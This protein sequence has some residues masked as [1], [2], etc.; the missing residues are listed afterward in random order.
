MTRSRAM[1]ASASPGSKVSCITQQPPAAS[2][3][4]MAVLRPAVQNSGSAVHMRVA[5]WRPKICACT[6]NCSVG[7][8]WL[9]SIPLGVLVVPELKITSGVVVG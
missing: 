1:R 7:A 5:S 6:Q 3:E 2:V 4:P 9:W 8:R